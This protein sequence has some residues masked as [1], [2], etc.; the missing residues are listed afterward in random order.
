MFHSTSARP[1]IAFPKARELFAIYAGYGAL[2]V[3]IALD[4][5]YVRTRVFYSVTPFIATSSHM[6]SKSESEPI[7]YHREYELYAE[8]VDTPSS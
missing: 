5:K 6:R 1:T 3:L 7:K 8:N 4:A 2:R